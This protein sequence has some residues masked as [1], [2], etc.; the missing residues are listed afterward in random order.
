M[1][2]FGSDKVMVKPIKAADIDATLLGMY[3]YMHMYVCMYV[4]IYI[5]MYICMYMYVDDI[6]ATLLGK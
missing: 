5:C 1:I 3:V 6:D 2:M 4:C